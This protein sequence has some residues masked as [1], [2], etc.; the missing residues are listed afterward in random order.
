MHTA[1]FFIVP[2]TLCCTSLLVRSRGFSPAVCGCMHE[3]GGVGVGGGGGAA[4]AAACCSRTA[5]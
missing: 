5:A 4:A 1:A 3:P 2:G